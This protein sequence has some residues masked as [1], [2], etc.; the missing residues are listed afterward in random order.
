MNLFWFTPLPYVFLVVLFF[1]SFNSS[2]IVSEKLPIHKTEVAFIEFSIKKDENFF[3][4]FEK[5]K[6][7]AEEVARKHPCVKQAFAKRYR[8]DF[9]GILKINP[10][11]QAFIKI[12]VKRC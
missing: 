4:E 3:V 8:I 1:S 2:A 5:A 12:F 10:D 9:E 7:K 11:G 6:K